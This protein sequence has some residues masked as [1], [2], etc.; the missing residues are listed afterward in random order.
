MQNFH[1]FVSF[2]I[3]VYV[4]KK[5]YQFKILRQVISVVKVLVPGVNLWM[6][7]ERSTKFPSYVKAYITN[8]YCKIYIIFLL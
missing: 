5:L 6:C 2:K 3:A 7:T 1:L 4:F 8:A